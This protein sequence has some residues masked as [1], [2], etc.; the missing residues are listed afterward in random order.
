M[1]TERYRQLWRNHSRGVTRMMVLMTGER[2][3]AMACW[4]DA[5]REEPLSP[6]VEWACGMCRL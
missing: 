6:G 1:A 3:Y 5:L 4:R 2:R